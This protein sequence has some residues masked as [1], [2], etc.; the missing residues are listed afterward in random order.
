[1]PRQTTC[2]VCSANIPLHRD[3]RV[4]RLVYCSYCNAQLRIIGEP[5]EAGA[6]VPVKEDMDAEE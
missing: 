3:D 2:P 5:E 6:D 1:M 4:G